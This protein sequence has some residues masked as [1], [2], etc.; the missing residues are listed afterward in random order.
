MD[1]FPFLNFTINNLLK[2][3]VD[4]II[5]ILFLLNFVH[6]PMLFYNLKSLIT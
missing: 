1:H 6:F 4:T 2:D 5:P 3:I